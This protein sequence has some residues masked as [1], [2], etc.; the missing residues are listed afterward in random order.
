MD[1]TMETA[2]IILNNLKNDSP[3][4]VQPDYIIWPD[5]REAHDTECNKGLPRLAME[6]KYPQLDFP[7]CSAEWDYGPHTSEAATNR[8]EKVRKALRELPAHYKHIAIITHRGFIAYLVPGA[9][10]NVCGGKTK[11]ALQN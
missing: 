7:S 5:L 8:A 4:G 9:R 1:R 10:F 2:L 6:M 3:G 11:F